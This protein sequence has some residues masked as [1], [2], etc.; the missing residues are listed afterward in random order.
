MVLKVLFKY[1]K[2]FLNSVTRTIFIFL[3]EV[4]RKDDTYPKLRKFVREKVN[5]QSMS[6]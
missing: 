3:D 6:L 4:G 5:I 1:N 2:V